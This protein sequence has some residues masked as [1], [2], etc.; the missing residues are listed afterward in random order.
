[1]P[2][3]IEKL[4]QFIVWRI[5]RPMIYRLGGRPKSGSI[6]FSPSASF[7]YGYRDAEKRSSAPH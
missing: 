7:T 1:M 2:R 5:G 4:L 3:P 6:W